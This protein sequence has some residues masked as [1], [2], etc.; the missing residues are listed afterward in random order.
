MAR[1]NN[2]AFEILHTEISKYP[3]N[4]PLRQLEQT[5][6]MEELE[7]LRSQPDPPAT[8]E[9][10][11]QIVIVTYP[12]FSEQAL[13]MAA[14]ANLPSAGRSKING[15]AKNSIII[16]IIGG[17]I[18]GLAVAVAVAVIVANLPFP[19]IGRILQQNASFLLILR[20]T[21]MDDNYKQVITSGNYIKV[22]KTYAQEALNA[23]QNPPHNKLKLQQVE[24]LFQDAIN[25]LDKVP[26]EDL[27]SYPEA[28]QLRAEYKRKQGEVQV[29]PET[30][31]NY[32]SC[33]IKGTA[34]N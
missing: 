18:G 13:S 1:L 11:R 23:C 19:A 2:R 15:K 16:I 7:K 25:E 6:V 9:E 29:N 20:F 5:L 3:E 8:L 28:Q 4:D 33:P 12:N 31:E 32:T 14:Q 17:L 27:V 30:Q 10:L 34:E 24:N 21:S 26:P 22:A